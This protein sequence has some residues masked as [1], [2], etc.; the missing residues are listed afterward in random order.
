MRSDYKLV[1]PTA[2]VQVELEVSVA[3]ALVKMESFSKHSVSEL[4]NTA[5]KRFIAAH[6]DFLP[7]EEGKK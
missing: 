7:R 6:K 3:E 4:A 5:L 1:G 2:K